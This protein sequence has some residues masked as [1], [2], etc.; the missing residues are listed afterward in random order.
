M[1][2]QIVAPGTELG[3]MIQLR[4]HEAVKELWVVEGRAAEWQAWRKLQ[5]RVA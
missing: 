4:D 1:H 3:V 2:H 5:G